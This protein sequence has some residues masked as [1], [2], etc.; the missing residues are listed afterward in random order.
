M[1]IGDDSGDGDGED[2]NGDDWIRAVS[3]YSVA[4]LSVLSYFASSRQAL[5][6]RLRPA[7]LAS[8]ATARRR[9]VAQKPCLLT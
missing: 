6:G 7:T 9:R 2:D 3:S 5:N 1:R 4:R 8:L